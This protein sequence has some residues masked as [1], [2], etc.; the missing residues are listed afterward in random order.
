MDN[1]QDYF[2]YKIIL[3]IVIFVAIYV[4]S[5]KQSSEHYVPDTM[6]ANAIKAY[7]QFE[8][9]NDST[10]DDQTK[11]QLLK[12]LARNCPSGFKLGQY[13]NVPT[14]QLIG[15][16]QYGNRS[17]HFFPGPS[18]DKSVTGSNRTDFGLYAYNQTQ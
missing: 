14:Q 11:N 16:T 3:I 7:N 8:S 10:Q 18:W 2:N 15:G 5:S 4:I 12:N 13:A 17:P 9:Q 6:C 1:K